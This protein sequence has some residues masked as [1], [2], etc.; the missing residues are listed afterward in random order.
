MWGERCIVVKSTD[1]IN[2]NGTVSN[3]TISVVA[4]NQSVTLLIADYP[5]STQ[6][7]YFINVRKKKENN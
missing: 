1:A 6:E 7:G 3:N 4:P 5:E 2:P